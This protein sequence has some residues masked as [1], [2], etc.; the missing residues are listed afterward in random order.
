MPGRLPPPRAQSFV[1]CRAIYE[2]RRTGECLLIGPF[3]GIALHFFPAGFRFSLY[4]DICGGHGPFELAL[5]LRDQDLATVWNWRW[6]QPFHHANP[7]EPRHV[8]LH[9]VVVEF[10]RPGRYDLVLLANGEDIT[11]HTLE[12][13]HHPSG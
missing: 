12:V 7:L 13:V 10:P 5:E 3:G 1:V 11:Q 2:D 9:D 4:A 8:I 6:P